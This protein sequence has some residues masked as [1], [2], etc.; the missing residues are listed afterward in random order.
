M[1]YAK[2]KMKG[3]LHVSLHIY[4]ILSW[5]G[6]NPGRFYFAN[7]LLNVYYIYRLSPCLLGLLASGISMSA[8]S[9]IVTTT[10]IEVGK[11]AC[12]CDPESYTGGGFASDRSY[13]TRQVNGTKRARLRVVTS[14]EVGM[15]FFFPT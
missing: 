7:I 8:A 9:P 6:Y 15:F 5:S 13:L 14:L 4:S 3:T 12:S 11:F 10:L 2:T 1:Q